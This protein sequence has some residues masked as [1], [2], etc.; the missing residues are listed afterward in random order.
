MSHGD[1]IKIADDLQNV[2]NNVCPSCI[3][4]TKHGCLSPTPPFLPPCLPPSFPI[5]TDFY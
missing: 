4:N 1:C 3:I 5:L 2:K